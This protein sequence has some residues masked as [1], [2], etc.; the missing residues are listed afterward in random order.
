MLIPF[1]AAAP[2]PFGKSATL[3]IVYV[4]A[5]EN[6]ASHLQQGSGARYRPAHVSIPLRALANDVVDH[7]LRP[8]T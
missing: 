2:N 3:E 1:P 4:L 7:G 5:V 6:G 8:C